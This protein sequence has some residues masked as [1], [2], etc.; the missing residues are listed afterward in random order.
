MR[1]NEHK[2]L[3]AFGAQDLDERFPGQ[4]AEAPLEGE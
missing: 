1:S 4:A 3:G 2:P